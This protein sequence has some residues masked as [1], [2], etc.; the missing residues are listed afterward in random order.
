MQVTSQRG[1]TL[2][3][4]MVAMAVV[5]IAAAGTAGLHTQQLKMTGEARR[6]TEATALAQDLVENMSLWA[7]ND[8]R[9]SN[10]NTSN[11]TD[12]GDS[13]SRFERASPP[14]DHSDADLGATWTG[15]PQASVPAGF[16][17]YWNV[18]YV[19]D[20]DGNAAWDAVRI[21]VIVRWPAGTGWRR[22]VM[23]TSKTNPS[24]VR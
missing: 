23:I 21:A 2:L 16:E 18:A 1:T 24:E 12:I 3:E 5:L 9:L 14:A 17:R 8:A 19:D 11:D 4:A 6:I 10:A 20:V 22:V 13:Q 7:F 15:I